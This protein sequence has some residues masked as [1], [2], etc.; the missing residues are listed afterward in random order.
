MNWITKFIKPKIKS[1]FEKKSSKIDENFWTTCGCKNLIYKEDLQSNLKCCPKCGAHH[2]LSCRE[3]FDIFFDNKEYE[4]IESPLPMDDP[5]KFEDNKKYIDRLKSARKITQQN[6]AVLI[7]RGKVKDINVVVGA[8]DFRFIGGS[9]GAASGEAFIAGVQHSIE[10][11]MPFIF[12]SC[13]GGQRMMESSI[14]L[15]QMSR[16]AL[17]VSE[18]K[19]KNVP[20][21]VVLTNPTTG[22]V[23]ASWAMLGDILIAEPKATIGFAGR[24]VIQDTVRETL[25]EEFQTAEYVKD[26][27]G[28]DLVVERKY[29]NSTIGT[30]L[31]VLLKKAE[32]QVKNEA[33]NVTVDQSLQS[34]S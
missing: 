16:T 14:A 26:H 24:R 8:Q 32:S 4:L 5:L 30:F 21:V 27:G 33:S 29:L 11:N 31:S 2:K 34:A 25:P 1:L 6:D 12:F 17:A 15:M 7:A 3:R 20:Y 18:L 9:F 19:K 23:T 28:I 10:N 22:G 13:S